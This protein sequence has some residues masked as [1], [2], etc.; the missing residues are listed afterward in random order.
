MVNRSMT[1]GDDV[2]RGDARAERRLLV[3]VPTL[4]AAPADL[5]TAMIGIGHIV[6][7]RAH[8]ALL[9][10]RTAPE[11]AYV[12]LQGEVDVRR[13]G[14]DLGVCR[15]GEI[16]GELGILRRRLRSATVV[17]R[18]PST[19]L[20]LSRDAFE[21]LHATHPYFRVLVGEAVSRK[22]G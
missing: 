19:V 5:L 3:G 20:H 12:L 9:A 16:L 17:T 18:T 8:W 7:V 21:H 14:E 10:E 11:K 13:H 22:A 15:P 1:T 4:G 6:P 2:P